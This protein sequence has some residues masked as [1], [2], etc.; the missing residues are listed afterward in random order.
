MPG[1]RAERRRGYMKKKLVL[2]EFKNEEE[3]HQFWSKLDLSEYYD[4][5]DL[6]HFDLKKFMKKQATPKTKRITIRIPSDWIDQAKKKAEELDV[7]YQSLLKQYISKGL[8][9][10]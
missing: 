2:P 7:P 8:R 6:R 5:G 1:M 9:A 3:E 4:P 10:G